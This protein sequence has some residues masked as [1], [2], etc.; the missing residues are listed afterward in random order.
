[1]VNSVAVF[2]PGFRV[3][4]SSTGAPL[5]GAVIR[6]YDAGT[7]TQKTVYSDA[8][9]TTE[10]G[11]SVT[12]DALGYPVSSGST[13]TLIYVGT[14]SYKVT[15][16]TSAGVIIASHDNC[17]GAVDVVD[18]GDLSVT[19]TTPVV[20][21]SLSYTVLSA[22]QS[23]VFVGNC[24]SGDVTFTLP[25]AVAVGDGWGVDIQHAG[26]AN[27]VLLSTVSSQAI[28]SGATS[29]STVMA[30]TRSGESVRLV[31]DGGN[32]RVTSHTGPHIK[33]SQGIIT[34]TDRLT[35]PPGS[36]VNGAFYLISG[37][38]SGDWASF[39]A[40]DLVQ[41]TSSAWVRFTPAEG[42]QAW[43]ADEDIY[44]RYTGAAWVA[45]SASDTVAGT[46]EIATQAEQ[47]TAT[48]VLRAVTPGRQH[49]HPSAAK[50]W[51]KVSY[52]GGTPS[53]TVSNNITS[54]TDTASGRLTVTIATD[55]SSA[56]YALI[57]GIES[58]TTST[59]RF[60]NI[61]T[62]SMAAGSFELFVKDGSGNFQ[63]PASLHFVVFGD[64]A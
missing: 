47:E 28:N 53:V 41:Y 7:D 33:A 57:P 58:D 16:E 1:M 32:W 42:W 11:T 43:V 3:T 26:S 55:I 59:P 27:Q 37:T 38:P 10:L 39:S 9:L 17:V 52:S 13:K 15:I 46:I 51:G 6:F 35:A 54:V 34:V 21:K 49:F 40:G 61:Q 45:E 63:D 12:T 14:S 30:L 50:A 44:Y 5:S 23:T 60:V 62:G 8:S 64:L 22:D 56:N 48:D 20:T 4:D 18:P 24:S 25:S 29:Y 36:E 31:S 2:T 19:A